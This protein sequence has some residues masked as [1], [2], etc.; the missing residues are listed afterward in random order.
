MDNRAS[1]AERVAPVRAPAFDGNTPRYTSYPTAVQFTPAVDSQT[2]RGWL[3]GLRAAAPVSLYAHIPFCSRLCWYC[4]CSTRAVNR[5]EPVADYVRVLLSEIALVAAA[6]PER[7]SANALHF[8]GG[9]P[10]MLS[11][12][13][14][15]AVVGA[16]QRAF[17]FDPDLELS[18][19]LDPET[20]TQDW[21]RGV[22]AHRLSRASLGVQSLSP[23]VQAAVNR[24]E[25]FASIAACV[26]WLR[27][28]GT[29][30]LNFDLM[31]GLPFQTEA[32]VLDTLDQVLSLRPDRLALFGYAHV[33]WVKSHQQLID[34]AALPGPSERLGQYDAAVDLLLAEGFVRI[35]LDHFARPEDPLARAQA[36][37]RL[38]RN[39]QGY[40]T[41]AAPTL[42]GFGASSISRL[43]QGYAQN[44]AQEL[45]W[46][47]KIQAGEPAVVR[48]VAL[49][50]DDR[51][52]ADIIERLMCD[53]RVDLAE[54]CARY[55]QAPAAFRDELERLAPYIRAGLARLNG[56]VV[57]VTL[58][59]RPVIRSICSQFD[60]YFV[61]AAN[62]HSS[63][64]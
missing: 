21:V 8:G 12:E 52:R 19:E 47:S 60:R 48:G 34:A 32:D 46:R 54:V 15:D 40:T 29:E 14:F 33:P 36:A 59:G 4:G 20:L 30:G 63:T 43:P 10:N 58:E 2:Y 38:H 37:G 6:M 22:G 42:L 17:A 13:E 50:E 18:V 41:D 28:A 31:Y 55:D 49:S 25:T 39:F 23:R 35:G 3:S 64:L 57:S 62:R 56:S 7:L 27:A 9:T 11:V 5:R 26:G 16:F 61:A 44:S 53:F 24:R 1:P 51:L 45:V